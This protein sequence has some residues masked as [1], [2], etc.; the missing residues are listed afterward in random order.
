MT[1]NLEQSASQEDV[2]ISIK[3]PV[4]DRA[5]ERIVSF[6]KT[7]DTEIECSSSKG[8]KRINISEINYIESENKTTVIYCEKEKIKTEFRLYQ[9]NEKLADKGFVQVSKYCILNTE[10]LVEI[11]PLLNSRMEVIMSN[12]ARLFISRKYLANIRREL[13]NEEHN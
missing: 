8:K 1:L 3:Y 13:Q 5:I 7:V 2:E 9:L 4:M 11:K 10:K 6:I 12:G